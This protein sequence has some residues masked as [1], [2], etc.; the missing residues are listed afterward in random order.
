MTEYEIIMKIKLNKMYFSHSLFAA[1]RRTN[2]LIRDMRAMPKLTIVLHNME[3]L[4]TIAPPRLITPKRLNM[5]ADH[6]DM[7]SN[8]ELLFS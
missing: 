7:V 3:L 1:Q 2:S 6:T 8:F 5:T 4:P